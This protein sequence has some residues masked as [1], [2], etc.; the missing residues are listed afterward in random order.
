MN[1]G[2]VHARVTEV[3]VA[4]VLL[5]SIVGVPGTEGINAV[6]PTDDSTDDPTTFVA[7]TFASTVSPV[8]RLYALALC[9]VATGT[10]H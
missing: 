4:L 6:P 10:E 8:A 2:A 9:N 7:I 1:A 5:S 3:F